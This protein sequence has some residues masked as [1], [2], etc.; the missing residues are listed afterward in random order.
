MAFTISVALL[1]GGV[2]KSTTAIALA[3]AASYGGTVMVI[4][5]DPMSGAYAWS[6]LA[7]QSGRPLRS[8]V[9][10]M[11]TEDL[12]RR[13]DRE[14]FGADVVIIDAPPPGALRIVRSAI[15]VADYV[16]VPVP[17]ETAALS[18]VPATVDIAREF[19]KPARAVLTMVRAGL[20][21]ERDQG[22]DLLRSWDVPV[23]KTELPLTVAVQRGFGWPVSGVLARYG[24]E[25]MTEILE[26]VG[27]HA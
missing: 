1:K 4:D 7:A 10:P 14:T 15:A 8:T 11:A 19:G 22:M 27:V 13:I 9:V 25:L 3:E 16:V 18:R 12:P 20:P 5:T 17:P 21:A 6:Q 23:F 26:E 24:F 2:G